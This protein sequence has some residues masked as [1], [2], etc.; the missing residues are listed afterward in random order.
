MAKINKGG[1]PSKYK[2]ELC[3]KVDEYLEKEK[4]EYIEFHKTRGL[5]SD[6]FDRLI[7]VNL[8][9]IY[10]FS[11]FIETPLSTVEFWGREH[12]EF[13]R[14][15]EK[16]KK[17]QELRLLE[18]GLSGDY[19]STI[20]KLILSSNHGYKE[21]MDQTTNDKDLPSPILGNVQKNN[22]NGQNNINEKK[23]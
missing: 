16:I 6:S 18:N 12:A 23:D 21:R 20:A 11:K 7:Q 5:K 17:E 14:A 15:L 3:D 10:G 9:T 22:G 13:L 2:T 4:D 1:R 8:P 19:N